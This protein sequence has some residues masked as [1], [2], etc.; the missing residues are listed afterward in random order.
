M[1]KACI[2]GTWCGT[3]G[4]PT[5]ASSREQRA[6]VRA[7]SALAQLPVPKG[8]DLPCS[9]VPGNRPQC[10]WAYVWPQVHGEHSGLPRRELWEAPLL[11]APPT[12]SS[13]GP[14]S[15]WPSL[16]LPPCSSLSAG[17]HSRLGCL[18]AIQ[19]GVQLPGILRDG[20]G[21]AFAGVIGMLSLILLGGSWLESS[22][23][24]A[25][26]PVGWSRVGL[27][28]AKALAVGEG[29]LGSSGA[30]GPT[31]GF[32]PLPT[33]NQSPGFP[34]LLLR[35]PPLSSLALEPALHGPS[36]F[37]SQVESSQACPLLAAACLSFWQWLNFALPLP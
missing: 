7:D 20:A 33:P 23:P 22:D 3:V 17:P 6:C 24:L 11:P 26:C 10:T 8:G 19:R 4:V 21:Q 12:P 29:G 9:G 14:C 34:P 36:R 25:P 1:G 13:S 30:A 16:W 5:W 35:G 18:A 37:A 28:I 31:S 2:C 32:V 27:S 15:G